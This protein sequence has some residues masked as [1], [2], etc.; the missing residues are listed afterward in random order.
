MK[1]V[2]H[3]S[4]CW[5]VDLNKPFGSIEFKVKLFECVCVE[6]EYRLF[7][8]VT[9]IAIKWST[10]W[11]KNIEN[12]LLPCKFEDSINI[13]GGTIL[14]DNSVLF[15]GI[16]YSS[17]NFGTFHS[18]VNRTSQI[19]VVAHLRGCPCNIRPC[20]RLC[21]PL[22]TFVNTK[23]LQRGTIRQKIP[24]YHHEAAKNFQS[25]IFDQT[26]NQSHVQVLDEYFAYVVLQ[27]PKKFYKLKIFRITNVIFA[28]DS[29]KNYRNAIW[30]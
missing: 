18:T 30:L 19:N 29:P 22:G 15:D 14:P 4:R 16:K 1:N 6:M 24:C 13:T 17:E 7:L 5:K 9:L 23:Q 3:F 20:L 11:C 2:R 21:C 12:G 10:V 28:N 25:E 26:T 27:T 8:G